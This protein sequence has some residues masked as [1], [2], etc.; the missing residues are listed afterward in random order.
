LHSWLKYREGFS[1][2]LVEILIDQF[3]IDPKDTI[4]DP[5]AGSC[6]TLLAAKMLGV[7]GVGIELLPH[8]HLAWEAKSRVFDYNL[9][10][11]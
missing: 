3:G 7:N 8:C 10:E 11:L 1:A 6:T 4:L 5:F 2:D 9:N